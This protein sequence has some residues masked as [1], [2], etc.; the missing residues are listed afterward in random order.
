VLTSWIAQRL[1]GLALH[2]GLARRLAD[3][4][5]HDAAQLWAHPHLAPLFPS[6][7]AAFDGDEALVQAFG[8]A[9]TVMY[10]AICRLDHL[11]D[12]DPMADPLPGAA[13]AQYNLVFALYVLAESLLDD[14]AALVP[15]ARL[16][17]LRRFWSDTLLRMAD[18]QQRD[19]ELAGVAPDDFTLDDY[20]RI[21]Q[22]KTG[23]TF[24]LAFGGL[25]LLLSDDET[26]IAALTYAGEVYGTLIQ[27]G[28]DLHDAPSQPNPTLTLP[29]LLRAHPQLGVE[30][31]P[32]RILATFWAHLVASYVQAV[33][34]VLAEQ[35]ERIRQ[36]LD[37]LFGRVFGLQQAQGGS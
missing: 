30:A 8:A 31:D 13:G 3:L 5:S 19:L 4:A 35:P 14:L 1:A 24:A 27:Y 22:A 20:Q 25:A 9:W 10:V 33:Q 21:A 28:D 15:A 36:Q 6:L 2:E 17:R 18:G 29:L 34:Q 37:V 12:G 32:D 26:T 7:Q 16:L 23:A 11:Q